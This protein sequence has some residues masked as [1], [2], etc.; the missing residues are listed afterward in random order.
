LTATLPALGLV[1]LATLVKFTKEKLDAAAF[2]RRFL[3][4]QPTLPD[5]SRPK[6]LGR[7]LALGGGR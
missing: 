5:I 2:Y 7:G 6:M 3:A 4:S 1:P